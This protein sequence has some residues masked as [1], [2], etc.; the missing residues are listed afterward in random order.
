MLASR[1]SHA[2]HAWQWRNQ[3]TTARVH[4]R[5]RVHV[6]LQANRMATGSSRH[7]PDEVQLQ[8]VLPFYHVAAGAVRAV[9]VLVDQPE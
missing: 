3:K 9:D 1:G 2:R 8:L 7:P 4:R 5:A 6:L